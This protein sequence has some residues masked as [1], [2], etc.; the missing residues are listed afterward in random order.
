MSGKP[1]DV[2]KDVAAVNSVLQSMGVE[3]YD[4][5]VAHQLL[6]FVYRYVTDVLLDAEAYAEHAGAPVGAV[7]TE[8]VMIAIQARG[9]HSFVQPPSQDLT[10]QLAEEVNAQP[11]PDIPVKFGL[12]I[13]PERDCLVAPN[14]QLKLANGPNT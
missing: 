12:R 11:L 10:L 4:P 3:D 13:P 9:V 6:D 2:P 5:R 8:S 1:A 14:Y 7:D